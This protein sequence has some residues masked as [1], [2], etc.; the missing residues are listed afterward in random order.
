MS[1]DITSESK[2]VISE[3]KWTDL[4]EIIK[5]AYDGHTDIKA[6]YKNVNK[7]EIQQDQLFVKELENKLLQ[8]TVD[9][10]KSSL[11][12]RFKTMHHASEERYAEEAAKFFAWVVDSW[13]REEE[14][15]S[16]TEENNCP[17]CGT[18]VAFGADIC[19]ICD[20]LKI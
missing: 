20:L 16:T 6:I 14:A 4:K 17:K 8:S 18:Y 3:Q 15:N 1:K 9:S 19:T 13:K 2:I 5:S 11:M 10:L 12:S 7:I